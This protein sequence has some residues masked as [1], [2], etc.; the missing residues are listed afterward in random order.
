[1]SSV[2]RR[3]TAATLS[4]F[5]SGPCIPRRPT[6]VHAGAIGTRSCQTRTPTT[7]FLVREKGGSSAPSEPPWLS[8][9][10]RGYKLKKPNTTDLER[11]LQLSRLTK[12]READVNALRRSIE[13]FFFFQRSSNNFRYAFLAWKVA[14]QAFT[15]CIL[16]KMGVWHVLS[17]LFFCCCFWLVSPLTTVLGVHTNA[18]PTLHVWAS[19]MGSTVHDFYSFFETLFFTKLPF[20]LP[21]WWKDLLVDKHAGG[22]Q[23]TSK[24]TCEIPAWTLTA[25][26]DRSASSMS[27][28][29][30]AWTLTPEMIPSGS[31][32]VTL[33]MFIDLLTSTGEDGLIAST[34]LWPEEM[35]TFR[36]CLRWSSLKAVSVPT[37][38]IG[39]LRSS[40]AISDLV[41]SSQKD[42]DVNT[43]WHW[44]GQNGRT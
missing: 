27:K 3:S 18:T 40:T 25:F 28:E 30:P 4:R 10:L 12:S 33:S 1:M 36:K 2:W 38:V 8:A 26:G 5:G 19:V 9:W 42:W 24:S 13:L 21:W 23:S 16:L 7:F 37:S 15:C 20:P 29:R 6:A 32:S 14:S 41:Y 11:D 22:G 43:P 34:D 17:Q 35:F 39:G 44:I 31:K